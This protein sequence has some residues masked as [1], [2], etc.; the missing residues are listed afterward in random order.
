MGFSRQEYWSGLPFPSSV[1]HIC[2]TSP[3]WPICLGWPHT[4]WLSFTEL[5]KAVVH[6]IRLPSFL[7][8]WFQSVCPLMPS[9]NTYRLTWV[10]LILD[11]GYLFIAAPAKRS[12]CSWPWTWG[13]SSRPLL[14]T[15]DVGYLLSAAPALHIRH[16]C[17]LFTP[18][19]Q[20][21]TWHIV[22]TS[23]YLWNSVSFLNIPVSNKTVLSRLHSA[24]YL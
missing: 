13:I 21:L 3:P 10:S 9:R 24:L 1:N 7:W 18:F 8:L 11:M 14:L 16:S 4:A 19:P 6:M 20:N 5:D 2:Q 23:E 15:W 22:D 12:R 17:G